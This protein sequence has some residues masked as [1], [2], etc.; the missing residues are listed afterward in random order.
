V[1]AGSLSTAEAVVSG[2][3]DRD[4]DLDLA[5]VGSSVDE[6]I[7]LEATGGGFIRHLV[8]ATL[9]EPVD[10]APGDIDCD[11]DLD[12]VIAARGSDSV[13]WYRND[14]GASA[15]ALG[16]TI[17]TAADTPESYFLT[18]ELTATAAAAGFPTL[19]V[20]HLQGERGHPQGDGS[21]GENADFDSPLVREAALPVAA[22]FDVL[23]ELPDQA[24]F[25]D[26]FESGDT[27]AWETV[28]P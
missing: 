4:G 13:V 17:T 28:V 8:T 16:A 24:I 22:T 10:L 1:P 19:T 5:A 3:F 27:G 20:T 11:G 23:A 7:W 6:V 9:D 14:S 25:A 26:G 12:L 15:W 21:A 18:V 2:D